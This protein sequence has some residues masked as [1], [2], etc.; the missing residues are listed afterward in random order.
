[1]DKMGPHFDMDDFAVMIY[2]EWL[3]SN[4]WWA[5]TD[6]WQTHTQVDCGRYTWCASHVMSVYITI[7]LT[8]ST[9]RNCRSIKSFREQLRLVKPNRAEL[10]RAETKRDLR[11]CWIVTGFCIRVLVMS[12]W[13]R[14]F[15]FLVNGK[16][17]VYE[18]TT[19]CHAI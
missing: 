1:M 14:F 3:A 17:G 12:Y 19:S 13:R 11:R 18:V 7:K 5:R 2:T 15:P 6:T 10:S 4:S 16:N 9:L 8:L